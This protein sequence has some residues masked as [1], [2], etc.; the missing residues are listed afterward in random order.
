MSTNRSKLLNRA[1]SY[2][3]KGRIQEAIENYNKVLADSPTDVRILLKIADLY[4]K[5]QDNPNCLETYEK[6]ADLHRQDGFLQKAVAIYKNMVS[7]DPS[8]TAN[9]LK[10]GELYMELGLISEG[11]K[12]FQ[13][14]AKM[15]EA[16]DLKKET[17]EM[18]ERIKILTPT[19]LE[20]RTSLADFHVANDNLEEAQKEYK[21]IAVAL[22]EK[23]NFGE[24]IKIYEKILRLN[25]K[26]SRLLLKL[27]E[28]YLQ[29]GNPKRAMAR[30]QSCYS[31]DSKNQ[32]TLSLLASA[33]EEL[34]QP[35]QARRVY[36]ELA[37]VNQ[38]A[39]EKKSNQDQ[40]QLTR[41]SD[42]RNQ[43]PSLEQHTPQSSPVDSRSEPATIEPTVIDE[44][45]I[46]A[47][48]EVLIRYGVK[49]KAIEVLK[50]SLQKSPNSNA[51]R[52]RLE[53]LGS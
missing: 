41:E 17:F 12:Q 37:T 52:K 13:I 33:F 46:L 16:N 20:V 14:V 34:N 5:L 40:P 29:T 21:Y 24:L 42:N 36:A 47:D 22:Q 28:L 45:K 26:N 27:G 25:R 48:I 10:L 3:Q 44:G 18:L 9:Q 15:Y 6:V 43:T 39:L 7:V 49:D 4:A 19:N 51:L 35:E 11:V 32:R 23:G 31:L 1:Q 53:E 38:E 30:L 2:A 8:I 50:E